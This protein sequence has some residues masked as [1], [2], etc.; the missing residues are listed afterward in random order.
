MCYESAVKTHMRYPGC[1][2]A[3]SDLDIFDRPFFHMRDL[4]NFLALP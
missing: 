4:K 2:Y 3:F 1:V